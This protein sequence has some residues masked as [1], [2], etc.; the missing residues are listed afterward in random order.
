[1]PFRFISSG[2]RINCNPTI[3]GMHSDAA[4]NYLSEQRNNLLLKVIY[5]LI[6]TCRYMTSVATEAV[7]VQFWW[8]YHLFSPTHAFILPFAISIASTFP[9]FVSEIFHLEEPETAFHHFPGKPVNIK[10]LSTA[11]LI[12]TFEI[13]SQTAINLV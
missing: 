13:I 4:A 5:P 11:I 1:M 3:D 2:Y 9:L 12:F 7:S 6:E 10:F 8:F